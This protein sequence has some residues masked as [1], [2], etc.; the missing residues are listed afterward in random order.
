MAFEQDFAKTPTGPQR[1]RLV[2]EALVQQGKPSD[3]WPMTV[4][5]PQ[6]SKITYNITRDFLKVG[7]QYVPMTGTTA[8]MIANHFGMHLPTNTIADQVWKAAKAAGSAVTVNPLSG[9]G[10]QG[11]G[12]Q[13]YSPSDVVKSRIGATDA[14]IAFSN[15]VNE[16]IAQNPNAGKGLVDIGS[17]GKWLTVPPAS[18]SL[19]LHGIRQSDGKMLQS[20]YGTAH[21]NYEDHTEYGTYVRLVDDKVTVQKPDG[22]KEVMTMDQFTKS[23]YRGALFVD[24][25]DIRDGGLAQYDVKRDRA[26]LASLTGKTKPSGKTPTGTPGSLD[27]VNKFLDQALTGLAGRMSLYERLVKQSTDVQIMSSIGKDP[28]IKDL[29]ANS[30][31]GRAPAGYRPLRKGENNSGIGRAASQIL[32]SSELGDQTPFKIGDQLYMG[33]TEPHYH[34]PPP[35]GEDPSKYPKPWGWHKGVTVF[36]ASEGTTAPSE[37]SQVATSGGPKGRMKL[38]QRVDNAPEGGLDDLAKLFSEIEGDV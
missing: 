11:S 7:N 24:G 3:L 18:G 26:N 25:Q 8:Q 38:L 22:G 28:A 5:G 32:N 4:D 35:A 16:Q 1:E 15:K 17:G 9:T 34:P 33:R 31:P 27:E 6:G 2:Y 10:Y 30:I 37:T 23:P 12:G 20:G 21:P 29:S 19:G 14:A 36:I 13:W